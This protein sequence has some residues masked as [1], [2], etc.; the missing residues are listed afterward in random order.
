VNGE[1]A[2]PT[3]WSNL[4]ILIGPR[5]RRIQAEK[6]DRERLAANKHAKRQRPKNHST[7]KERSHLAKSRAALIKSKTE[8]RVRYWNE[9]RK[10][11]RAYWR[12]ERDNY[13]SV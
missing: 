4:P 9:L 13:P 12:G 3:D 7:N 6:Q 10:Q 8:A 5:F 11:I 2:M 1:E